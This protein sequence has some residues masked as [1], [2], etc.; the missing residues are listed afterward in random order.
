MRIP[1]TL[2]PFIN[3][4]MKVLLRSPLHGLMSG[5]V[6]T[7]H[8]TGRRS[9]RRRATPVRYLREGDA[10]VVCLT[11][12]ETAWWHNF[13]DPA[14]VELQLAGRRI[15]ATA[16]ALPDDAQRKAA[17]LARVLQRFPGD[18]PYR[19]INARRGRFTDEQFDQAVQNDVVVT[20]AL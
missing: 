2:F 8:F 1:E 7:I 16:H 20:F 11:S 19:G 13:R 18:A 3:R 12:R 17:V 5:S 10:A 9:G 4:V 14:A 6:M 15:A